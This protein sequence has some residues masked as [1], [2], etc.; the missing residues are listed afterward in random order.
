MESSTLT[1]VAF[2]NYQDLQ[3][4]VLHFDR[5]LLI[6]FGENHECVGCYIYGCGRR[7][8]RTASITQRGRLC[9]SFVNETNQFR[10]QHLSIA[11]FN[12]E[13]DAIGGA[14]ET[15][16]RYIFVASERIE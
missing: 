9:M 12:A 2:S 13:N 1:S 7:R 8:S 10:Q 15:R 4:V 11:I 3:T 16:D 5:I 6:D 14:S